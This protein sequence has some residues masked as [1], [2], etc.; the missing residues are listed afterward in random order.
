MATQ[1]SYNGVEEKQEKRELQ[2]EEISGNIVPE[3]IKIP[4][5]TRN[6]KIGISNPVKEEAGTDKP[7][8]ENISPERIVREGI[9]REITV[10]EDTSRETIAIHTVAAITIFRKTRMRMT[11]RKTFV[12]QDL[13]HPKNQR[14]H[15]RINLKPLSVWSGN[16]RQ[17]RKKN[18]SGIRQ[19]A[20]VRSKSRSDRIIVI[21]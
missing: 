21:Y 13:R 8:E 7:P 4:Q 10:R 3:R 18:P 15:N 9:S 2:E 11:V 5:I 17:L 19:K 16:K 1:G 12:Q 20:L 6:G 14:N